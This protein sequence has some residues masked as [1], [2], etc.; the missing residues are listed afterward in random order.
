MKI[1]RRGVLA[2]LLA[3]ALLAS[4]FLS[5]VFVR[6]AHAI[7]IGDILKIGG[8]ILVVSTF[9]SQ[10]NDFINNT[11]GQREASLAGATKVVPVF[12][13]GRGAYVG[14]AQVVGVPA[15]VRRVQG[16]A[17]VETEISQLTGALVVPITTRSASGSS[18]NRV[19]GVGVSA[20]IDFNL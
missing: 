4:G 8:I 15:N 9:G 14:A 12:S 17:T 3:V 11:L 20:V 1:L 6:P 19:A 2:G 13:V 7:D 18:L 10:M 5:N 16:V